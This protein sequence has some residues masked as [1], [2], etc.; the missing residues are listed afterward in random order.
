[1]NLF[2]FSIQKVLDDDH[3]GLQDVKDRLLEF[4]AVNILK[5][6]AQGK[7]ICLVGPPGVGKTSIGKSIAR[8]LD[9]KF[10]R[11]CLGAKNWVTERKTKIDS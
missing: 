3:Y 2:F 1:M 11:F 4:M 8:A 5:K 9:R 7:I 10:Y 6:D